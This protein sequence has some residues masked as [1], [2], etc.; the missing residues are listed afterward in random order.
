MRVWAL[1]W[2]S[3]LRPGWSISWHI[4]AMTMPSSS[5]GPKALAAPQPVKKWNKVCVTLNAWKKLWKG[6]ALYRREHAYTNLWRKSWSASVHWTREVSCKFYLH[7]V[8]S[9]ILNSLIRPSS[10]NMW[11][12]KPNKWFSACWALSGSTSLYG[13]KLNSSVVNFIFS[14]A[15]Y[16]LRLMFGMSNSFQRNGFWSASTTDLVSRSP[17]SWLVSVTWNGSDNIFSSKASSGVLCKIKLIIVMPLC[18]YK[19]AWDFKFCAN[20]SVWVLLRLTNRV[21]KWVL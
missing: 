16:E 12:T 14:V 2:K 6:T 20:L 15:V 10:W 4:V 1:R 17:V 18:F 21:A 9:G 5:N 3:L 8:V 13:N 19:T 11:I 7:K